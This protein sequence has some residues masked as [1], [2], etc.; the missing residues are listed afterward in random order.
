ML[1]IE[2]KKAMMNTIPNRVVALL[3]HFANV[4]AFAT[5]HHLRALILDDVVCLHELF[6]YSS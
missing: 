3:R 6:Q 4:L 1:I 5:R 2:I